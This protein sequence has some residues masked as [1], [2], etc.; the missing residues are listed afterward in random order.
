M[1]VPADRI[2]EYKANI[3]SMNI[4]QWAQI[5]NELTLMPFWLEGHYISASIASQLGFKDVALAILNSVQILL[6]RL[7]KLYD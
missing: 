1:A 3:P 5:E 6:N 7:P 4:E 2:R